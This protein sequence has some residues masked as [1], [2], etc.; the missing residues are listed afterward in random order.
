MKFLIIFFS[1]CEKGVESSF[2][3][4]PVMINSV[5]TEAHIP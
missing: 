2:Y 1:P 5:S 4:L 3:S